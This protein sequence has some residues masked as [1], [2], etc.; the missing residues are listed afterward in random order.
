MMSIIK[1]QEMMSIIKDKKKMKNSIELTSGDIANKLYPQSIVMNNYILL[2][3]IPLVNFNQ[4]NM[5]RGHINLSR[6]LY[7]NYRYINTNFNRI[8]HLS[9]SLV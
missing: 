9:F 3:F 6:P 8:I 1:G 4:I 2:E 7:L 5:I